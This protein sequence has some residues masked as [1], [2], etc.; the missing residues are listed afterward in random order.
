MVG[1][2]QSVEHRIVAPDVVGSIP[3]AHPTSKRTM[4][5]S[6]LNLLQENP[7]ALIVAFATVVIAVLTVSL[8]IEN[9]RLRKISSEPQIMAYFQLEKI[10]CNSIDLKLFNA[11][12]GPA[13]D[14][15]FKIIEDDDT[16]E[17]FEIHKVKLS[18]DSNKVP[19]SFIPQGKGIT[20]FF[21]ASH[22]LM[23]G[24]SPLK[25]F[26]I[27][28]SYKNRHNKEITSEQTLD[29]SQLYGFVGE[30]LYEK[31]LIVP[32]FSIVAEHLY[33]EAKKESEHDPHNKLNIFAKSAVNRFFYFGL[34]KRHELA[35][36][37]GWNKGKI[38]KVR[39]SNRISK[40]LDELLEN[41][42]KV[43]SKSVYEENKTKLEKA[44]KHL[45]DLDDILDE[46]ARY[47][48]VADYNPKKHV[49]ID[50]DGRMLLP[51]KDPEKQSN[52]KKKPLKPLDIGKLPNEI[53]GIEKLYK[54]VTSIMKDL[55]ATGVKK[56]GTTD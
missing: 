10:H 46:T 14:I 53:Q 50:R 49:Y 40:K 35:H 11:G 5:N 19:F 30:N 9:R 44:K 38:E 29:I 45:K 28:I 18:M 23:R 54:T 34:H 32:D 31:N 52:L 37:A 27:R 41:Q 12:Q 33:E 13:K 25:P 51:P 4:I 48:D 42:S 43:I 2:A 3:I 24:D 47:R 20:I 7:L 36:K 39:Y 17:D 16:R 22:K 56:P 6:L 26:K 1:V 21:G 8:F 55:G 15:T